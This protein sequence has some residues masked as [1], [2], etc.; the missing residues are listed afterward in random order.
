MSIKKNIFAPLASGLGATRRAAVLLL[1][2]LLTMTAQT[3]GADGI[4]YL[5]ATGTQQSYTTSADSS[6]PSHSSP[7]RRRCGR[8]MSHISMQMVHSR[9]ALPIRPLQIARPHGAV[10]GM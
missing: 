6:L 8:T 3:A 5:D 7:P 4:S 10:A 1:V 9:R 2:M